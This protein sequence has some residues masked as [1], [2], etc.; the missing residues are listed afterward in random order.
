MKKVLLFLLLSSLAL[1][2]SLPFIGK[3][4]FNFA[5]GSGTNEY[6]IIEKNGE[7][8]IGGCGLYSCHDSYR[9]KYKKIFN[10]Y[11]DNSTIYTFTSSEVMLL[12]AKTGKILKNCDLFGGNLETDNK[13]CIQK[14]NK[15]KNFYIAT[16]EQA[17]T[18]DIRKFK[19]KQYAYK[20]I[21]NREVDMNTI[22]DIVIKK[23]NKNI[24][25]FCLKDMS[26]CKTEQEVINFALLK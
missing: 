6:I 7:T 26:I 9:G 11:G 2:D 1:A 18:D 20:L 10:L 15:D 8:R 19:L 13:P 5:G 4:W 22:N 25:I 3:A 17:A 16:G 12:S 24:I 21:T 23:N 14:L